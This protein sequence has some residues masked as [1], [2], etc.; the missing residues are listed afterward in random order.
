MR[1]HTNATE[2]QVKKWGCGGSVEI[3]AMS[4]L[5]KVS[6]MASKCMKNR[7]LKANFRVCLA[8]QF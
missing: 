4:E 7:V 5:H 8:K 1:L 6:V 3:T 2:V